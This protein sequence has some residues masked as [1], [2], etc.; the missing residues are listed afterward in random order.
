MSVLV[1]RI[2]NLT[3]DTGESLSINLLAIYRKLAEVKLPPAFENACLITLFLFSQTC[4]CT[5]SLTQVYE[6]SLRAYVPVLM[7]KKSGFQ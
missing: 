1:K 6:L 7:F 3:F 5:V 2:F 4:I